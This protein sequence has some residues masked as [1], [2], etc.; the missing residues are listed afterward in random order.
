MQGASA[1]KLMMKIAS[2][3]IVGI[4]AECP[5]LWQGSANSQVIHQVETEKS[6]AAFLKSLNLKFEGRRAYRPAAL[7]L[8]VRTPVCAVS[9]GKLGLEC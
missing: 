7:M 8:P 2:T 1:L 6:A 9:T 5:F 3:A 4:G